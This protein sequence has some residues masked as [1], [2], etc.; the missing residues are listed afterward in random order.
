M[1]GWWS[2]RRTQSVAS[3]EFRGAGRIDLAAVAARQA[4]G[5]FR[6]WQHTTLEQSEGLLKEVLQ[7]GRGD[8]LQNEP[9]RGP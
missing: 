9:S 8:D 1:F 4:H 3:E 2:L 6:T 5:L 7:P